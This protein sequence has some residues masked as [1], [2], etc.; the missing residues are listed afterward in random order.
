MH[1]LT[2][3]RM[4]LGLSQIALAKAAGVTQPDLCEMET[5]APYGRPDKYH[6]VAA[7]LGLPLEPILKNSISDIPLSFFDM[8]PPQP[9]LPCPTDRKMRIGRE[10]EDFVFARERDRLKETLPIHA[11]LVLPL[12]KMKAQRIG[13]DILSYDED[14]R[15]VCLEVKT[16]CE[17]GSTFSMTRNELETARK[18]TE[19]GEEYV[20]TY[21]TN[22]K[23]PTQRVRDISYAEFV[24]RY[25]V[26]A[27]RFSCAP[28]KEPG[29][30][31][32]GLAYFRKLRGLKER[33]IAEVVGIRQDKWSL[34]ETGERVPPVQ[35]LLKVS[36]ALDATV[37]QLLDMYPAMEA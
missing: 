2:I 33:E 13:C 34:Y 12:Y 1:V 31:I 19:A 5:M 23:K 29:G 28:S 15:P 24:S 7:V 32:T 3:I 37:D 21:I 36:D 4:Y 25:D 9:Y 35:V 14:G 10:G 18:L 16:T 11:K 6:R 17:G 20:I 30:S 26:T 27:Q 22:W 8:H